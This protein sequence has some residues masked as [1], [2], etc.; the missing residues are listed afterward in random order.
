MS[1]IFLPVVIF[2]I[3]SSCGRNVPLLENGK[4]IVTLYVTEMCCNLSYV[5]YRKKLSRI[6]SK[7]VHRAVVLL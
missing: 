3:L 4:F 1:C 6:V 5:A 7:C 2:V